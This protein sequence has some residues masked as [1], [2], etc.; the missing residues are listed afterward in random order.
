MINESSI[1]RGGIPI[2]PL[3]RRSQR[4]SGFL[5]TLKR[6]VVPLATK[7]AASVIPRVAQGASNVILRGA[8][9]LDQ[10]KQQAKGAAMDLLKSGAQM[11]AEAVGISAPPPA[12]KRRPPPAG[13]R[14]KVPA[15][16]ARKKKPA[17]GWR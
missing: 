7:A 11:A 10:L 14:A 13:R 17:G 9:P 5:S 4:G 3:R 12:R 8:S 6:F 1:F 16:K 2:L 15:K